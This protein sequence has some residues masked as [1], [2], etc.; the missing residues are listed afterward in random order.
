VSHLPDIPSQIR[1]RREELGL[2]LSEVARRAGTSAATISRYESRWTRFEVYTL[3]KLATA[4]GCRLVVRLEPKTRELRALSLSEAVR[5][6]GRLFWDQRLSVDD[7][8]EYP[9]WVVQRVLEYGSLDDVALLI[10][11]MGREPFLRQVSELRFETERTRVFWHQILDR[12]GV[13][14]TSESFRQEAAAS[15]PPSRA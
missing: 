7:L 6:L 8:E 3:R 15:W 2:T 13:P 9:S 4:L 1:A 10:G 12:E 5:R 11:L 14:C